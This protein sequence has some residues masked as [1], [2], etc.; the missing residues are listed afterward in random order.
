[1]DQKKLQQLT[2]PDMDRPRRAYQ[3]MR[4]AG[5]KA[6]YLIDLAPVLLTMTDGSAE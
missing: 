3:P 4:K 2:W 6:L 5:Q 1:M